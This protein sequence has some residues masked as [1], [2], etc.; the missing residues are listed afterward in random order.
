MKTFPTDTTLLADICGICGMTNC[1]NSENV[2][3]EQTLLI[4]K[5]ADA[6]APNLPLNV[7]DHL[8]A[9]LIELGTIYAE[10]ATYAVDYYE[11][12][13]EGEDM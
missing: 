1:E 5:I 13:T 8:V 11:K 12:A 7:F 10:Y 6:V 3:E 2:C 4:R 9:E